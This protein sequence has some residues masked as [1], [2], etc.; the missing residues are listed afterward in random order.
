MYLREQFSSLNDQCSTWTPCTCPN[1]TTYHTYTLHYIYTQW[2]VIYS[3]LQRLTPGTCG[4]PSEI[5]YPMLWEYFYAVLCEFPVGIYVLNSSWQMVTSEAHYQPCV[6]ML[7]NKPLNRRAGPEQKC[8]LHLAPTPS[9][10]SALIL[11]M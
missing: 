9:C 2:V 5:L 1:L 3:S 10:L 6:T 7:D 8:M 11:L 4:E